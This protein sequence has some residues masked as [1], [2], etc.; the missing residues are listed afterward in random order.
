MGGGSEDPVLKRLPR[1]MPRLDQFRRLSR[2][3]DSL[4]LG[5][6]LESRGI[7]WPPAGKPEAP[8]M[9]SAGSAGDV[10]RTVAE[11]QEK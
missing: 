3:P 7:Q 1:A 10:P 8:S 4:R 11:K 5:D 9:R 6:A 2:A